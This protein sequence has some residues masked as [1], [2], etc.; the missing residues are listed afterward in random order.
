MSKHIA[1]QCFYSFD[2][3]LHALLKEKE[4]IHVYKIAGNVYLE[5]TALSKSLKTVHITAATLSAQNIKDLIVELKI[6][7]R[8]L[9][10]GLD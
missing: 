2:R 5:I 1:T 9:E 4:N 10:G 3:R 7:L 8:K 6:H